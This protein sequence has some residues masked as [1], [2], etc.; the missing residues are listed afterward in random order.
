MLGFSGTFLAMPPHLSDYGE[1]W[2]SLEMICGLYSQLPWL[3]KSKTSWLCPHLNNF[4]K[5][6]ALSRNLWGDPLIKEGHKIRIGGVAQLVECLPN[7][8]SPQFDIIKLGLV[9]R[10]YNLNTQR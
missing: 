5:G 7:K 9:V 1:G 2:G 6:G 3:G 10:A 4:Q 8:R